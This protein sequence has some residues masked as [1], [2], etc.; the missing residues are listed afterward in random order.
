MKGEKLKKKTFFVSISR[1]ENFLLKVG[2]Y[3]AYMSDELERF[4]TFK[5]EMAFYCDIMPNIN[6]LMLTN[7]DDTKFTAR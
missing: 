5:R 4:S 1:S 3:D 7:N 6:E 2:Y